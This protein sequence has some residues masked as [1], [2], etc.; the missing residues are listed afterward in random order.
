MTE[1]VEQENPLLEGLRLRRTPE[2]CVLVIFGASGD[3]TRR[4]LLPALYALAYRDLLPERFAVVGVARSEETDDDF[5][6]RMREAVD[7]FARDPVRDDVWEKLASGMRYVTTDFSQETGFDRLA[8][9]LSQIDAERGT[10]GNRV[11]Y[12]AIP[13]RAFE[14]VVRGLGRHRTA[15]GFTR[16]IVEKPFGHDLSSARELNALL[17]EEFGEQ[18]VFRIDHYLGKETVQ[19]MLALRF[20]NGIFEPIW[21]RQ[22][23]DHVQITVAESMGIEGRAGFYESAGAVRDIFQNHLLQLVALT[24]MEPPIDFTADSVRNEK[25]KVLK[26]MHTPGPKNVVRGQYGRG[27]AVRRQLA[28]GRHALLRPR[29]Q[30]AR[31]PGDDDRD[32]VQ[33]RAAPALRGDGRRAASE[34]PPDPCPAG[35]GR[36]A[37]DRRE[38]AGPGDVDPH[39]AH[40]LPLRRHLPR[41]PA[42]GVRAADPR[43]DARRRDPLH[44]HRRGRGAVVARRRD[45]RRLAARPALLPELRGGHLGTGLGRRDDPPGRPLVASALEQWS[46]KDVSVSDV[47]RVLPRLRDEA[48]ALGHA[49]HLRTSVM[50]HIAWVPPE[51]LGA[52]R[53]TLAGMAERHPSRTLLLVPQPD[54]RHDRIDAS[55]W[56]QTFT[57][58]QLD[59]GISTEV[60]ELH[61]RGSTALAPASVVQPLLISDLPVFLRWRGQ[62]DYSSPELEQLV[63]VADRLIVDSTEW[64]DLPDAYAGLVDVFPRTAASD[65]AWARTGRWRALLASLWPGIASVERIHVRG[66][67][68]QAYLLAG[69]LR[70]RLEKQIELE[71]EPAARLEGI[72]LDGELERAALRRARALHPRPDLRGRGRRYFDV[73]ATTLKVGFVIWI[74]ATSDQ[75]IAWAPFGSD[76]S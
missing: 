32:P 43:R 31:A 45:R 58:P 6:A 7:E 40:G 74:F 37:R 63:H 4:K 65:I 66:T 22:F 48:T 71:F 14:P 39:R 33:A 62:P 38:G 55:A 2:P 50:T 54:D 46:E 72:D 60:V 56:L 8:E 73:E 57:L 34:R 25:V 68:A 69:W 42:G 51:W 61:L 23:I 53:D 67:A 76:Q 28:L 13:P 30:A 16:L 27:E 21:N 5:R 41:G 20:A 75:P 29:R 17:M 36:L 59:R 35:R 9:V 64:P 1:T 52:A 12:L 70:S 44:A 15:H 11:Y 3:L 18:E 49:P 10:G 19:N 47:E 24:A 26:S